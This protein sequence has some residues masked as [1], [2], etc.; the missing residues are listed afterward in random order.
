MAC[1]PTSWAACGSSSP[2]AIKKRKDPPETRV[3]FDTPQGAQKASRRRKTQESDSCQDVESGALKDTAVYGEEFIAGMS[4]RGAGSEVTASRLS[5]AGALRLSLATDLERS[6]YCCFRI[7]PGYRA[8]VW[9][10]R[11]LMAM[12]FGWAQALTLS[13][14]HPARLQ[15]TSDNEAALA[16]GSTHNLTVT[17]FAE[18]T[19]QAVTH[20]RRPAVRPIVPS[21]RRCCC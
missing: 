14:N 9:G 15:P 21:R 3:A 17:R 18:R 16:L 8:R 20:G 11:F 5:G 2:I 13:P 19:R 10:L 12:G 6:K 4:S 7:A 1:P